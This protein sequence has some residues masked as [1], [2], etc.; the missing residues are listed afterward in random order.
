MIARP[1]AIGVL[2]LPAGYLLIDDDGSE[3]AVG[4]VRER[5]VAG[6]EVRSWP[7]ALRGHELAHAGRAEEAALAFAGGD[8]VSRFNRFVLEPD[9]VDLDGLRAQLPA[10][11]APLVGVV[12]YSVGRVDLPPALGD[13]TAEVAA[14]VLSAQAS[15][16]LD[17]DHP[18][19]AVALLHEAA[20]Q[21]GEDNGPLQAVVLGNAGV[22]AWEHGL[23]VDGALADL[24]H[25][26]RLL[27]ATDLDLARAELHYQLGSVIHALAASG[28]RPLADAVAEFHTVLG[29]VDR[30]SAPELWAAANLSIGTAYLT[31][32]MTE[33][34]DQLRS[35]IAMGSLRAALEV[36]T[37]E[38][39]PAQWATAQVN[40][41]NSLVYAPSSKQGDNL[42]EAVERYE[43]V[44][45]LRD[46][47]NDPLG[48]ARLL[49]NQGNA[50]A[51]LGIFDHA[52][53]K[54]HE[55]RFLFEEHGDI[56][57]V[58]AVRGVLDEIAR[59]TVPAA[60]AAGSVS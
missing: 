13:A 16:A 53:A 38:A 52:K 7:A 3:Q 57:A 60:P 19:R 56:D 14:L 27:A 36:F 54:L 31:M 26:V 23:D 8:P 17:H 32:P 47:E 40:L 5:L 30:E 48:R 34:T 6:L 11:V 49:A 58:M 1:Q 42:V 59:E 2:P 33:A 29:L 20:S 44:L 22:V 28:R 24:R 39:Y 21:A 35:G 15:H 46:R 41:A 10:D 9:G 43:E 45:E 4:A 18:A 25:A 55:A 50:L 12:A 51:H 37:R